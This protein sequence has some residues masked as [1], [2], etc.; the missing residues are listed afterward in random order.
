MLSCY[1]VLAG[2][3]DCYL[4]ILEKIK[5]QLHRLNGSTFAYSLA[6]Q[7]IIRNMASIGQ[8]YRYLLKRCS[9]ELVEWVPVLY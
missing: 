6:L 3:L 8:F 9:C 2:A 7:K 4:V 5:K 1:R